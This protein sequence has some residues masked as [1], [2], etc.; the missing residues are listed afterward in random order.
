MAM[1]DWVVMDVIEMRLKV[2]LVN[3]HVFLKPA[4]PDTALALGHARDGTML[5]LRQTAGK[6]RFNTSPTIGIVGIAFRQS[7]QAMQMLGQYHNGNDM[8]RACALCLAKSSTQ[9][10]DVFNQQPLASPLQ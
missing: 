6:S 2:V 7:P 4:L 3:D 5:G 10:I 1:L 9:H 8:K